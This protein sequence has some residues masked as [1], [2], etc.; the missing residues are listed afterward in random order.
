MTTQK[1]PPPPWL[2]LS[3]PLSDRARTQRCPRCHQ[4]VIRALVG[5]PCGIDVR[6]D[7]QAIDLEQE[8]TARLAGR[9]TYCLTASTWATPRLIHR[10][11]EHISAGRCRHLVV[12][13]HHCPARGSPRAER[14]PTAEPAATDRLF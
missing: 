2:D 6:A 7:P 8:L 11:P 3:T 13:D 1:K 14:P 12:A 4:P 10:S 5:N 9:L